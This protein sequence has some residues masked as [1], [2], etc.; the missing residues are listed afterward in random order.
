MSFIFLLARLRSGVRS[1]SRCWSI[2]SRNVWDTITR[3]T[4]S[5]CHRLFTDN[6]NVH[7]VQLL[8]ND[9]QGFNGALQCRSVRHI[10]RKAS[11]SEQ[12]PSLSGFSLT[13]LGQ[14][15]INPSGEFVLIIPRRFAMTNQHHSVL[16]HVQGNIPAWYFRWSSFHRMAL[17]SRKEIGTMSVIVST[18]PCKNTIG[19]ASEWKNVLP[20]RSDV[21]LNA[22]GLKATTTG[23]KA[24]NSNVKSMME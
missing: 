8:Q 5:G 9:P 24:V 17:A 1:T 16:G 3:T 12:T 11:F 13:L 21:G 10:K 18:G 14:G 2:D 20:Y 6:R 19:D 4:S 7:Q 22:V 15:A 23:K